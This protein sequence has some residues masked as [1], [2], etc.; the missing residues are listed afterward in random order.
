MLKRKRQEAQQYSR[1]TKC[2]YYPSHYCKITINNKDIYINTEIHLL[3]TLIEQTVFIKEFI[4]YTQ[5]ITDIISN[6][7]Q[8]IPCKV[9][10]F[11]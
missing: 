2:M 10:Y 11:F 8:Y 6:V 4:D 5:D 7:N 9:Y 1:P 3:K